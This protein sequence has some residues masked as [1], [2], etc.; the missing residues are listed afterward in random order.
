MS[1]GIYIIANDRVTENAIALLNSIRLHDADTPISMIPYDNQ[2]Q[3]IAEIIT[4]SYGVQ[5][6]ENLHFIENLSVLINQICGNKLF[7]RPNLLRKLACWF[8]PFDEFLYIDT[9]IVVFEKIIDNLNYLSDY[10]FICCD[11]Q[12]LGGI[13]QI[14]TSKIKDIFSEEELKDVFNS[15]FWGSKKNLISQQDLQETFT[16]CASHPEYFYLENSDQ[17]ILNYLILNKTSRRFNLVRE[18]GKEPGNWAGSRHFQQKDNILIDPNVNQPLKFLH[19]AGIRIEP[20][21]SY[22]DIWEHYRYLNTSKPTQ[23]PQIQTSKNLW[24]QITEKIKR[25]QN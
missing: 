2:Y 24:Q 12:H 15:G 4:K 16:F 7:D 3:A 11:Y 9:D 18:P 19:W 25:R 22:W 5:I 21:G 14:F 10:D 8:G 20:G 6:Y 13:N 1:R 17:T 23:V